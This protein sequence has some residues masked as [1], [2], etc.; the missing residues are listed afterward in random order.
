MAGGEDGVP[1]ET[2]TLSAVLGEVLA[3][4]ALGEGL[5]VVGLLGVTSHG[6]EAERRRRTRKGRGGVRKEGERE[7]KVA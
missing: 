3:R 2:V 6:G 5:G 1:A 4:L 7:C